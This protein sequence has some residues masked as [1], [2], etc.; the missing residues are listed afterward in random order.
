L[1]STYD[2]AR[3]R[4]HY[5]AMRQLEKLIP[6]GAVHALLMGM[7]AVDNAFVARCPAAT[8]LRRLGE[9]TQGAVFEALLEDGSRVA[10]KVSAGH[11]ALSYVCFLHAP[12]QIDI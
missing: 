4:L 12:L 3:L 8:P 6:R 5:N 10:R 11:R 7:Q 1:G 2:V 9:G